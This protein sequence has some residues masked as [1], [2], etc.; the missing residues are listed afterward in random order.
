MRQSS[1]KSGVS[2]AGYYFFFCD[3]RKHLGVSQTSPSGET[4]TLLAE[5]MVSKS[6][7]EGMKVDL[8]DNDDQD[9]RGPSQPF[10]TDGKW[11]CCVLLTRAVRQHE[12]FP[13]KEPPEHLRRL[14]YY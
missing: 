8:K 2:F 12:F 5:T 7:F 6:Q 3:R 1:P 10:A 14:N 4:D 11:K 9:D 13:I